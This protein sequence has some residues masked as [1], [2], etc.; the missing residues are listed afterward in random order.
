MTR[1]SLRYLAY[2]LIVSYFVIL[3]IMTLAFLLLRL[4]PGSFAD[5]MISPEMPKEARDRIREQYNLDEPLWRQYLSFMINYQTGEF[6]WSP[7]KNTE[8]WS[9]IKRRL[10]RTMVLFGAAFIFGYIIGP[11]VGMYLGWWRGTKRD[12]SI[13]AG[14]LVAY[15]MPA[16]W[17]AWLLI[18][19]LNYQL[20]WFESSYMMTQYPSEHP[21]LT[22]FKESQW[23]WWRA[24][25]DVL[26]RITLPLLSIVSVGWVGAMLVM[27]TQMNT[28]IDSDYVYLAK[29]KGLS[30]RTVMIK[31]AARNALIPVA[32][33]AIVGVAFI[34]DGA[35]IIEVVFSYPG[36]GELI[37]TSV[38]RRDYPTAQA[39]FFV[40]G[41]LIVVMRLLTDI[42]YTYLDPRISFEGGE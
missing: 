26:H 31:H 13:F 12:K 1:I 30:E 6:G 32:T 2:R 19:L 40:L 8:V 3:G 28:V 4:M 23:N 34:I 38:L 15:S 39:V 20:G 11:L 42:A 35:V 10:P 18:W 24:S 16:F 33:Q 7:S 17:I 41:V 5:A 21:F 29:A 37:L 22:P 25:L 9:L 27:R 36:M 14:G